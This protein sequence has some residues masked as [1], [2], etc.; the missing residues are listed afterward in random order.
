MIHGET[1]SNP[2]GPTKFPIF[3]AFTTCRRLPRTQKQTLRLFGRSGSSLPT[4]LRVGLTRRLAE[5][6]FVI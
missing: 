1:G 2:G 5:V 3:H 6:E 4:R